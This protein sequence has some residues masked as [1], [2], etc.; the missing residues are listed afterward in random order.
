MAT[1]QLRDAQGSVF[2]FD[3]V[4]TGTELDPF[5]PTSEITF[6]NQQVSDENPLPVNAEGLFLLNRILQLLKPLQNVTGSGSNRL[7]VDINSGSVTV[8]TISTVTNLTNVTS[9]TLVD[10]TASVANISAFELMKQTARAAYGNSIR[11]Q[12]TF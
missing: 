12:I 9:K 1:L 2:Y 10:N 5:T 8:S 11:N 6:Q 4:G 7:S 3:V